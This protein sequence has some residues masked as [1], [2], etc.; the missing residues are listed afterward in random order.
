MRSPGAAVLTA[1][2]PAV[3]ASGL[4]RLWSPR[5]WAYFGAAA[6]AL[7]VVVPVCN[8]VVSPESVFHISNTTVTLIGKIMCYA[9]VAL[10][11]DLI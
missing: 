2:I 7:L 6:L 1:G 4:L 10:A 11:M 3:G 8:L 5:V 9:I